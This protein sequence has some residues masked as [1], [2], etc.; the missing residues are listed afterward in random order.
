[1]NGQSGEGFYIFEALFF[2]EAKL[3]RY[4]KMPTFQTGFLSE[5]EQR[6]FEIKESDVS[7]DIT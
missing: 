5:E 4:R 2:Y 1:M 7:C 6:E 3:L